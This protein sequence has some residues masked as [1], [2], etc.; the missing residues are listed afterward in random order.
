MNTVRYTLG[1]VAL[2]GLVAATAIPLTQMGQESDA[3]GDTT[4]SRPAVPGFHVFHHR[5]DLAPQGMREVFIVDAVDAG[6]AVRLNDVEMRKDGAVKPVDWQDADL[7]GLVSA[8]D[9]FSFVEEPFDTQHILSAHVGGSKIMS[10]RY[11]G[12]AGMGFTPAEWRE[13]GQPEQ[14]TCLPELDINNDPAGHVHGVDD[15]GHHDDMDS[16]PYNG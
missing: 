8:G 6:V 14:V 15:D 5:S 9:V 4:A 2:A 3:T 1:A 16:E 7:D 11:A 12:G 13:M 10:C